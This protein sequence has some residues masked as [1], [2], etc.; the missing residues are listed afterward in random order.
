MNKDIMNSIKKNDVV[1]FVGGGGKTSIMFKIAFEA[2]SQGLKVLVTTTTKIFVPEDHHYEKIVL[3]ETIDSEKM[4]SCNGITV[5]GEKSINGKIIAS[6]EDDLKKFI[7]N[8]KFDLI[9]IEA[10]GS[11][12]KSI[13]AYRNNEPVVP[14]Y[15]NKVFAILSLDCIGKYIEDR[16]VYN[17]D[18]L[19][20]ILNKSIAS[21]I[22]KEDIITLLKSEKGLFENM[23]LK[24]KVIIL[25][26]AVNKERCDIYKFISHELEK[27]KFGATSYLNY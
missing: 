25:T 3:R 19:A 8:G 2:A 18:R 21:E 22:R 26:K 4:G 10:D 1:S 11:R 9:L 17:P 7:D 23:P 24:E 27:S 5:F 12:R 20:K 6:N 13:K 15:S 16:Y 14:R